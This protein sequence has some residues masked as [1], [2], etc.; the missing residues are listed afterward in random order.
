MKIFFLFLK[1]KGKN[2][3]KTPVFSMS[4][5][6]EKVSHRKGYRMAFTHMKICLSSVIA[7]ENHYNYS[8]NYD[9]YNTPM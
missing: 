5:I 9:T 3:L 2:E 6:K 4:R 1:V 7:R 8:E